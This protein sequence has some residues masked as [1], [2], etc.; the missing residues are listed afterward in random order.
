MSRPTTKTDLIE[1]AN[2]QFDKLWKLIDSMTK[3]E[4]SATFN[5]GDDFL[6][7]QEAAHWKRDKN[8]RDVLVHLHEWHQLLLNWVKF[9]Q[10]GVSKP[11]IPEPYNFK[12][13][14]QMNIELWKKHQTIPLEQSK[15]M[16]KESHH[17]VMTLIEQCTNDELFAKKHFSWTGT[18]TLGSYCVSAT[19]SHFDWA[20]KKIK[21]H[22]KSCRE[23]TV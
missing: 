13:Y 4:Q 19:S 12:T 15:E 2:A 22:I 20:I 6:Q 3:E 1:T 21:K 23:Q 14:G 10:G 11:F 8:L 5:F 9:N 17:K 7:K 18:S 16:L